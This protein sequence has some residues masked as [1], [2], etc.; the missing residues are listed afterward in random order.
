MKYLGINLTRYGQDI[1][2]E[3]YKTD[4]RYQKE[5]NKW[6]HIP[7]QWIGRLITVKILVFP[8]G[9]IDSVQSQSES[10]KIILRISVN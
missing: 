6:K 8:I 1:Y 4:E 10:Q 5:L 7:H 9:S 2:E 3:N